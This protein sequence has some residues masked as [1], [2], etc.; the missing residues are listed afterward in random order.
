MNFILNMSWFSIWI[1]AAIF[2]AAIVT[3]AYMAIVWAVRAI[4][5]YIEE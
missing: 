5:E 1:I 4:C 3:I 2:L